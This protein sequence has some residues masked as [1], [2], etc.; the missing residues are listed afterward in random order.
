MANVIKS[1]LHRACVSISFLID[2]I[3][4]KMNKIIV[5]I[6]TASSIENK[7]VFTRYIPISR[8]ID[9]VSITIT[10]EG[11]RIGSTTLP[12]TVHKERCSILP[13]TIYIGEIARYS[14]YYRQHLLSSLQLKRFFI[15]IDIYKY[16][17]SYHK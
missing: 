3:N 7:L 2:I 11:K 17:S 14:C 4:Y 10:S 1:L 6:F 16:D 5:Y 8:S 9:T 13:A 12:A 15:F